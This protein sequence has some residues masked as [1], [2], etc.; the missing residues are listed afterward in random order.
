MQIDVSVVNTGL[1]AADFGKLFL[2]G[3][4]T[5]TGGQLAVNSGAELRR[6]VGQS[7]SIPSGGLLTGDGLVTADVVN[8][9]TI[10][11]DSGVSPT[12][13]L[14]ISGTYQQQVNGSLQVTVSSTTPSTPTCDRVQVTGAATLNGTLAST[15]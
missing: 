7:L 6:P 10:R 13:T 8:A 12:S 4:Y 14:T 11:V 1:I 2:N 5:Q 3:T 15:W 9:G